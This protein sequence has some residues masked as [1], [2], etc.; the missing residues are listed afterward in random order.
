LIKNQEF[1]TFEE[2]VS[3]LEQITHLIRESYP[4]SL[5]LDHPTL[6]NK[7]F[8]YIYEKFDAIYRQELLTLQNLSL[9]SQDN[10][11]LAQENESRKKISTLLRYEMTIPRIVKHDNDVET[12]PNLANLLQVVFQETTM[13]DKF[14]FTWCQ[15]SFGYKIHTKEII[16]LNTRTMHFIIPFFQNS[17]SIFDAQLGGTS[18]I[19][20][21]LLAQTKEL[22]SNSINLNE[23][24]ITSLYSDF[25]LALKSEKNKRKI[26]FSKPLA[27]KQEFKNEGAYYELLGY[28][29]LLSYYCNLNEEEVNFMRLKAVVCLYACKE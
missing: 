17:T 26:L 2:L 22:L 20:T 1:S 21:D 11:A 4:K 9:N 5:S 15:K 10:S 28:L 27:L 24:Q 23:K 19:I 3:K 8:I 29:S 6:E 13:L 25:E 14:L 12:T 7:S 16:Q 18:G